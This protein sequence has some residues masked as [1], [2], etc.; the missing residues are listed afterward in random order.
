MFKPF[1]LKI[2]LFLLIAY[3]DCMAMG[4]NSL[5]SL[6]HYVSWPS[7]ALTGDTFYICVLGNNPF[8]SSLEELVKDKQVKG[9]SVAIKYYK[10]TAGISSCHLLYINPGEKGKLSAILGTLGSS[11][12]LTVSEYK[13]FATAG[14]MINFIRQGDKRFEINQNA[15]QRAKLSISSKILRQAKII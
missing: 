12:V 14:G 8:G 4:A 9:K 10:G 15:Y 11:P 1:L 5:F 13:G 3:S 6:T 7:S 2:L